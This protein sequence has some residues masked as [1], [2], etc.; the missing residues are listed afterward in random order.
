AVYAAVKDSLGRTHYTLTNQFVFAVDPLGNNLFANR[1]LL[2]TP[3]S[4]TGN[5]TGANNEGGEPANQFGGGQFLQWGA[6]LWW[7]WTAPFDGTVTIDTFGSAI[8]T[9]LSVYRGTA[10]N[11]LQLVARN[12]NAPGSATASLVFFT[13]T[14]GIEYQI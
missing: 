11:Q 7:K 1:Y 4:V 12:D 2:G 10:V 9:V 8:N 3:A 13:A 5:N 6:T 14:A